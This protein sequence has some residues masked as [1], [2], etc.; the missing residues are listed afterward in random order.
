M[1]MDEGLDTGDILLQSRIEISPNETGGSLHD[2]LGDLAPVSLSE[3][4]RLLHDGTAPRIPQNST[5]ATYAPKLTRDDGKIDWT[6][7]AQSIERKIRAFDPWPG[8]FTNIA[9]KSGKRAKLKIFRAAII[10]ANGKPGE[11]IR[12][13]D[14]GLI[15]ATSDRALLLEEVQM[16]GKRRMSGIEFARGQRWMGRS[17]GDVK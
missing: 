8:A 15:I 9:E 3:A 14:L 10:D 7:S 12:L 13:D 17:A 16:E 5:D 1:Y 6:E 4:V 11:I 2:R